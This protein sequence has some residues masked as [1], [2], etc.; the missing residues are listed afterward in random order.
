MTITWPEL[1][2]SND[3][4]LWEK[5]LEPYASLLLPA[6]VELER[7][8]ENM[9][10]ERVSGMTPEQ[11][12]AFL[13]DEYFVWKFTNKM[14]LARQ[15]RSFDGWVDENGLD[16]LDK[17]RRQLLALG[18]HIGGA[19]KTLTDIKG[20]GPAAASGLLALMYPDKFGTVD[21]FVVEALQQIEDLP[22]ADEVKMMKPANL[23]LVD[24]VILTKILR[25]KAAELGHGWTP[26]KVDAVLWGVRKPSEK[27][28]RTKADLKKWIK[29]GG[30]VSSSN[31]DALRRFADAQ[32]ALEDAMIAQAL[33]GNAD[34]EAVTALREARDAAF[35]CLD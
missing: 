31:L 13:R 12:R 11:W 27:K 16:A 21:R 19:L 25:R 30:G 17:V 15:L 22:E 33:A 4:G 9:G 26:R 20:I 23:T 35:L 6:N 7:R 24:G 2:A 5:A 1:W 10:T 14:F 3:P 29:H 18:P 8:L 28:R 34:A 32:K